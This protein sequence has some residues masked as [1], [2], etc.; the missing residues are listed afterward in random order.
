MDRWSV[1]I[2]IGLAV[3]TLLGL[4]QLLSGGQWSAAILGAVFTAISGGWA[5]L[6]IFDRKRATSLP[7]EYF[8]IPWAQL[9]ANRGGWEQAGDEIAKAL[10]RPALQSQYDGFFTR[11]EYRALRNV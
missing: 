5:A 2:T 1:R 7:A 9:Q 10:V 4:V 3:L 8:R 6:R 11:E